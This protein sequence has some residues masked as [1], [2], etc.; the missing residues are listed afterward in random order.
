MGTPSWSV[1]LFSLNLIVRDTPSF[2][3]PGKG[4]IVAWDL[5]FNSHDVNAGNSPFNYLFGN[6]IWSPWQANV[7]DY[8]TEAAVIMPD[9][10]EDIYYPVNPNVN[11][12]VYTPAAGMGMRSVRCAEIPS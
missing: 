5:T 10:R 2:Y 12:I 4:P 11:P 1:N 3:S 8:G 9:G 6:N 7:A